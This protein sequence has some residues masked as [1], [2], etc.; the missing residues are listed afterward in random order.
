ML[1]EN[2]HAFN[3]SAVAKTK[4]MLDAKQDQFET[5]MITYPGTF[6]G[7]AVRGRQTEPVIAKAREDALNSQIEFFTKHLK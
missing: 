7:F 5:T 2:D 3:S 6:H 1:A 4:E